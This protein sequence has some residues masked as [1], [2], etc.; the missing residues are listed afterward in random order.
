MFNI[1]V[2]IFSCA[3]RSTKTRGSG[4]PVGWG[5]FHIDNHI[6]MALSFQEMRPQ[7]HHWHQVS[8]AYNLTGF[9]RSKNGP[10]SHEKEE[11][12]TAQRRLSQLNPMVVY[13]E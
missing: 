1:K 6:A 7:S 11:N 4:G 8:W 12:L 3:Q 2:A 10:V 13:L 9:S 5:F